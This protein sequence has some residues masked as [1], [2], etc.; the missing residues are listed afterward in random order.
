MNTQAD[1]PGSQAPSLWWMDSPGNRS[2]PSSFL[3]YA[4]LTSKRES[5]SRDWDLSFDPLF[6]VATRL[7]QRAHVSQDRGWIFKGSFPSGGL[8]LTT[9]STSCPVLCSP[10]KFRN[11]AASK[12]VKSH[13]SHTIS[14]KTPCDCGIWS[15]LLACW[16]SLPASSR[17]HACGSLAKVQLALLFSVSDLE[18]LLHRTGDAWTCKRFLATTRSS[19]SSPSW[20]PKILTSGTNYPRSSVCSKHKH[21][22]LFSFTMTSQIFVHFASFLS[23][24]SNQPISPSEMLFRLLSSPFHTVH[25][26]ILTTFYLL[27]QRL[28]GSSPLSLVF[29]AIALSKSHLCD[30]Y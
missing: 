3:S 12:L 10:R 16:Q 11:T 23:A 29:L 24:C 21:V 9:S 25:Y 5:P 17:L 4:H 7:G 18:E 2:S 26:I 28:P 13:K 27:T 6:A 20:S 1:H 15:Q 30:F 22:G 8:G 14:P 19:P